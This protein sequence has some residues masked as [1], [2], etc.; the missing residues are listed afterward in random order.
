MDSEPRST[1]STRQSMFDLQ[2][3]SSR[4]SPAARRGIGLAMAE[5]LASAGADIIGVSAQPRGERQ[6]G[7]APRRGARAGSFTGFAV[8]LG[9]RA[10]GRASLRATSPARERPIDILVN[11]AGTIARA[12][13]LDHDTST[14]GPRA[15]GQPD[16]AVPARAGARRR[17]GRARR[18][19]DHLHRVAAQ[20]SGRDPRA[21]LHGREVRGRRASSRRSRT[22]GPR[23]ASTST[24]SRPATSRPTTPRR[25]ATTPIATARSSTGS[26]PAA[27]DSPP[28]SPEP[29]CFSPRAASDYVCG[30]IIAGRRRLARALSEQRRPRGSSA[31]GA[32]FPSSSPT[33]STR[34]RPLG[35]A[36]KRGGLP[37]AE[38]TFR[39]EASIRGPSRARRRRRPP[40]RRR[41][42]DPARAGRPRARRRRSLRRHA[43]ASARA[44]SSA[45]ASSAAGDPRRRDGDRGHRGARP[46]LRAAQ[47]LSR[48]RP[49]AASAMLR[50]LEAPFPDVRFIPTGG[51]SAANA[52]DYLR[53]PSVVGGRRQLD[54]RARAAAR[55][56]FRERRR[57]SP[58]RPFGSPRRRGRERAHDPRR[59]DV[60]LRPRRA[61]RGH[62]A[63]RS[64]RGTRPHRP[65][66]P[67]L[68]GRRR[69]QRRARPAPLLRPAHRDR[70]PRS[71]TTT[72]AGCSRILMLQGGVDTSLVRWVPYDGIGRAVRNGLN[73]TERGFGVRGALGVSDRG[74][75]AASQLA[76]GRLRLGPHLR[77]ARR[78]L[79][80]HRRDLRRAS[81]TTADVVEEAIVGR[82]TPRHRRLLRPQLPAEPLEGDR[83]HRTRPRGQPPA[84]AARRRDDR[85]R[86]GLHRRASGLRGGGR[87]RE[88]QRAR[89]RRRFA[90]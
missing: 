13:A 80:A 27:G 24:R 3:Q 58:R 85:Q 74:N 59:R 51:V 36:L 89:H 16:R 83:R 68:G 26:R 48:P 61:R 86:G 18:R 19:Q 44:S 88:P 67:R 81:E 90:R 73:F 40:R 29:R 42:R 20:L 84:R 12:P 49:A 46:R 62:A 57:A 22:S 63:P 28:T 31:P 82:R 30:T 60:P 4:S 54:G 34:C 66:V 78:A 39:T 5:A 77:R 79:A 10:G 38:V 7:G 33:S 23:T 11:N 43:R 15:R 55:G 69:V 41:H 45:A 9:D 50:A 65:R 53:L 14:L 35:D 52:A 87:R 1:R 6:R 76:P 70:R 25:C 75:T 8:D 21:E 72:S 17:N 64:R 37:V 47:V 71:P 32:S 56:R 2:R